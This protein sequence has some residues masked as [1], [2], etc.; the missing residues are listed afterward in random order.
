MIYL[1]PVLG[2]KG[3]SKRK[4]FLSGAR[5]WVV[6]TEQRLSVILSAVGIESTLRCC[7]TV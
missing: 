2:K 1:P 6:I 7:P 3:Q 4:N 5:I